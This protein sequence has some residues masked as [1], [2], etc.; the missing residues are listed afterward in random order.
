MRAAVLFAVVAVMAVP[1]SAAAADRLFV[2]DAVEMPGDVVQLPLHRGTSGGRV[3]SYVVLE[4][5]E[6]VHKLA[7]ARGTAAVQKVTVHDGVIDFPATVD[8]SPQRTVV[9][10]PT[11]FPPDLATP[12]AV[13]ELGYS[14]LVELPDGTVLNAPQIAN[15][16]GRADKVV[17][18]DPAAGTVLYRETNGEAR[19]HAVR[20]VSFDASNP[21]AAALEG[22][23]YA[24]ALDAAPKLDGDGTDSARASLAAVVNGPTGAGN[25][26]RQGLNSAL[27]DGL[28]P[29]NVLR[30][31]PQQGRYSPLWDVHL[32]TWTT[33]PRRITQW[34]DVPGVPVAAGF[35]VNCP[36]IALA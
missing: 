31:L 30:W 24:P 36:I 27:L 14:P 4:S 32:V 15:D 28:D 12:G 11:G 22:A 29:L 25:P 17:A 10:G 13:G 3:V 18:L 19:T 26:E 2:P 20:Y 8:F 9:P 5:S 6:R 21:L 34:D 23:T 1:S 16:T 35:I 7:H 33:T